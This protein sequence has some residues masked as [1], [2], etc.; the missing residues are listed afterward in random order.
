MTSNC[1]RTAKSCPSTD[2]GASSKASCKAWFRC[3]TAG[4]YVIRWRCHSA[5]E[6]L[7]NTGLPFSLCSD[8]V[9]TR[10]LT[11]CP[12]PVVCADDPYQ[13]GA[14]ATND[15]STDV[16]L[17]IAVA[18]F[19][20]LAIMLIMA[21]TYKYC[22]MRKRSKR[23]PPP[24]Q[25]VI[26]DFPYPV[27]Y[28]N[29]WGTGHHL[30][31]YV[32]KKSTSSPVYGSPYPDVYFSRPYEASRQFENLLTSSDD[33]M[34]NHIGEYNLA[35]NQH[36]HS[37]S[38]GGGKQKSDP[39]VVTG[40]FV[41]H[42]PGSA[43][44]GGLKK[45]AKRQDGWVHSKSDKKDVDG[46]D[47]AECYHIYRG[48]L[49]KF[50]AT[51][52]MS[53]STHRSFVKKEHHHRVSDVSSDCP[54][55]Q[56]LT[57][58]T[59]PS[60]NHSLHQ[61]KHHHDKINREHQLH[62]DKINREHQLREELTEKFTIHSFDS[63]SSSSS[64]RSR[65][66]IPPSE[67]GFVEHNPRAYGNGR[68]SRHPQAKTSKPRHRSPSSNSP[69]VISS[70]NFTNAFVRVG[71][72]VYRSLHGKAST[73]GSSTN[74]KHHIIAK[75]LHTT[76]NHHSTNNNSMELSYDSFRNEHLRELATRG[77]ASSSTLEAGF[78]QK[79][80]ELDMPAHIRY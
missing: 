70:H 41:F 54:H 29:L 67:M 74:T 34:D 51:E 40:S 11:E 62:H 57:S 43:G 6:D 80:S 69:D 9:Q 48:N 35:R 63:R 27:R 42:Q 68:S 18:S 61:S 75:N 37:H 23:R 13:D 4:D 44:V 31:D 58:I 1:W 56:R 20:V 22:M 8:L 33:S 15:L 32:N 76:N 49:S 55:G 25:F 39:S 47:N 65:D 73:A 5:D 77:A 26:R 64:S 3:E 50:R 60:F 17:A 78:R 2:Q 30:H 79:S 7:N 21:S 52:Q 19:A 16:I 12:P 38:H 72:N 10:D 66:S 28:H 36:G 53:G 46:G 14:H 24:R 45:E 59:I 71:M